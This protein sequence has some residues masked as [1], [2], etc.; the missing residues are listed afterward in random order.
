[1]L[2]LKEHLKGNHYDWSSKIKHKELINAPDRRNFDRLNGNQI[3]YL[4][5]SFGLSIGSLTIDDGQR[6]ENFIMNEIPV[7]LKSEIAVFNWLK[8]KYLYYWN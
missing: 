1:M 8:E 6:I 4:I 3:L 5:N 2:F 7:E